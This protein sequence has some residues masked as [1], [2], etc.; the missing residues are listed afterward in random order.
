MVRMYSVVPR[1]PSYAA[2]APDADEQGDEGTRR[3]VYDFSI[4]GAADTL[5]QQKSMTLL[6]LVNVS[7]TC[8]MAARRLRELQH[9]YD[10]YRD[11]GL[12]VIGVP[13]SDFLYSDTLV[14]E[15]EMRTYYQRRHGVTFPVTHKYRV[16][17]PFALD[18][19]QWLYH[20]HKV[21]PK[22]HFYQ[23]VFDRTGTLIHTITYF[24][25]VSSFVHRYFTHVGSHRHTI[26]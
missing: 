15:S 22:W 18:V 19:Y 13:A 20:A 24:S 14:T 11:R 26:R 12:L 3:T 23:Y 1:S 17:G 25:S 4:P 8:P 7:G 21:R 2:L 6:L 16:T 10:T 5:L 9:L